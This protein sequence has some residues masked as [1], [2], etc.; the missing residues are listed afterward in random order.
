MPGSFGGYDWGSEE[1]NLLH[2][3][4]PVPPSYSLENVT[5]KASPARIL[6]RAKITKKSQEI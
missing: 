6:S 2:H 1:K 4:S 3:G 5:A